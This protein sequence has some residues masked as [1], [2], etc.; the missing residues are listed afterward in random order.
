VCLGRIR[1]LQCLCAGGQAPA[2]VPCSILKEAPL[3][4]VT[5]VLR[6]PPEVLTRDDKEK[7]L[8][9]SGEHVDGFRDFI[10][11]ST[12]LGTFLRESE[13][14]ALNVGDVGRQPAKGP[15][16]INPKIE[17]QT[18]KRP[19]RRKGS[20]APPKPATPQRVFVPRSVRRKLVK[21][22][23]W[24]RRRGEPLTP[25]APLFLSRRGDRLSTRMIRHMFHSWQRAA[26]FR[27]PYRRFHILRHTGISE[28]Y[29]ATRDLLATRLQAR[30]ASITTT[31]I[32]M[33]LT[34][35]ELSVAVD[36]L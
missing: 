7:I 1:S 6:P 36:R 33:H 19:P 28:L 35:D 3:S 20:K 30:H 14:A 4:Y 17:L 22:F 15:A 24:K 31:Q 16:I 26:G 11:I 12:A 32:Y 27:P 25:D 2:L 29:R 18:F 23:A 34:D 5:N 13:I 21:F 10:I 8:A 9:A